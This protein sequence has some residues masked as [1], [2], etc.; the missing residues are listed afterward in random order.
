[1][2]W[3]MFWILT[4]GLSNLLSMYYLGYLKG[5]KDEYRQWRSNLF[6]DLIQFE[7]EI[8]KK[9]SNGSDS[10]EMTHMLLLELFNY[11]TAQE[12]KRNKNAKI[13]DRNK[14]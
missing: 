6:K 5:K 12:E 9:K 7:N 4:L 10:F 3:T 14:T 11:L 13:H 2:N 1:M 8:V